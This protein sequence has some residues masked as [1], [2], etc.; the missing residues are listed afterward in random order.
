M[1]V[2]AGLM[3]GRGSVDFF[4]LTFKDAEIRGSWC[5]P[6]HSWPRTIELIASGAIPASRVVTK[7]IALDQAVSEGFEALL[8]PNGAQLKI[9]IYLRAERS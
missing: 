3:A 6:T 4:Q 2:Q 7:R 9:L 5:Y 8:D 1:I